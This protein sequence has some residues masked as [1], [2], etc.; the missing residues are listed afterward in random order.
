MQ[1]D[2]S[3]RRYTWVAIILHW[4][5]ALGIATLVVMGLAMTHLKLEPTRLFQLL[6]K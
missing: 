5:M 2:Y 1:R 6:L 3:T 4:V